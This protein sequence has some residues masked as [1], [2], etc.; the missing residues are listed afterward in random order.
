MQSFVDQ[1]S[2]TGNSTIN[3]P[4]EDLNAYYYGKSAFTKKHGNEK[5]MGSNT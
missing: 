2:Y 3:M 1:A 4:E 5:Q